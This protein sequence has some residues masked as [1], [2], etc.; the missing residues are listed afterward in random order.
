M[1]A[2][3]ARRAGARRAAMR[4]Q[5]RQ[6]Q[7][8]Q[9]VTQGRASSSA[10]TLTLTHDHSRCRHWRRLVGTGEGWSSDAASRGGNERARA[11]TQRLR[12]K[13]Q[14][15]HAR[16]GARWGC[17]WARSDS[18]LNA[19][20]VHDEE[21]RARVRP[22]GPVAQ[23]VRRRSCRA[24][25]CEARKLVPDR[26]PQASGPCDLG[27]G[28]RALPKRRPCRC[29]DARTSTPG[30]RHARTCPRGIART[31]AAAAA[32]AHAA[33]SSPT[34]HPASAHWAE[35]PGRQRRAQS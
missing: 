35:A 23:G 5:R 24:L 2:R 13:A 16:S 14:T 25:S 10:F 3:P 8:P 22:K 4:P 7:A 20:H 29:S 1:Q 33:T 19:V 6:A 12:G 26:M 28:G 17:E 31:F 18:I 9:G 21:E 30:V 27:S 11:G 32:P 34:A 15:A